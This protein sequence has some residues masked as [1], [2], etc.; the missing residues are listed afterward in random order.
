METYR[1]S[2]KLHDREREYLI[3]TANDSHLNT[4]LTTIYVNGQP[5]ETIRSPH[6]SDVGAE[7]VLSLVKA[8]HDEKKKEVEA[9][10]QGYNKARQAGDTNMMYHLGTAFFFKG[11]CSEAHEMFTAVLALSPNHHQSMN[12]LGMASLALG[13]ND[14]AVRYALAA[15]EQ[16]PQFADY[17]NNLGEALL[18][19]NAIGKAVTE[20]E[21]A[22]EINLYYGD[23]YFNLG[24]AFLQQ[25]VVEPDKVRSDLSSQLKYRI[26]DSL[27][28]AA[29]ISNTLKNKLFDEA[30]AQLDRGEWRA[31]HSTL[32]RL[33]QE[34]KDAHRHEF[35]AFHMKFVLHPDFISEKLIADRISFLQNEIRKNPNYVDLM[36]ELAQCHIEQAKICWQKGVE[37]YRKTLQMHPSLTSAA[38]ALRSA[39]HIFSQMNTGTVTA[40]GET[41]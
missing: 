23:A 1:L 19:V 24:L 17:H 13:R 41:S 12:Y 9:L 11:L 14:D 26:T 39:E 30:L 31:A 21:S 38:A 18:A 2:S 37:Q 40:G 8:T 3:Q 25:I 27:N 22:L 32:L 5:A 35:A 20:F 10:L 36:S 16:R 29:L 15:A 34:K 4:V 28:K 33:R 7:E 6:P